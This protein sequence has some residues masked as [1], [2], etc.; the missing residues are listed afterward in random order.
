MDALETEI[1]I[2]ELLRCPTLRPRHRG[3]RRRRT[4]AASAT[5]T[6]HLTSSEPLVS[7]SVTTSPSI[8]RRVAIDQEAAVKIFHQSHTPL[9]LVN[10]PSQCECVALKARLQCRMSVFSLPPAPQYVQI[11]VM[12]LSLQRRQWHPAECVCV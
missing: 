6:S 8:I 4:A 9:L 3:W 1:D 12:V 5:A 2:A 7:P 10:I 11:H